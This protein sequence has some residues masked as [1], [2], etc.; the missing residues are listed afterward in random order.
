MQVTSNWCADVANES[1]ILMEDTVTIKNN[2]GFDL[3]IIAG[4]MKTWNHVLACLRAGKDW[5]KVP[6]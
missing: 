1:Y 4:N 6:N 2:Y 5:E 3:Q